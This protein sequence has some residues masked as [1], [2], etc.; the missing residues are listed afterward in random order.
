LDGRLV[1]LA[2]GIGSRMRRSPLAAAQADDALADDALIKDADRKA[3]AMI[4]V[5]PG[6][7]PFLDYLLL[8]AEAVGYR[9]VVIV[10]NDQDQSIRAYYES[11][12]LK[13]PL[14]DLRITFAIQEIPAGRTKPLGTADALLQ[15]L[16]SRPDWD[17]GKFTICN[18]DNL[19][20]QAALR[21]LL[22]TPHDHALVAYDRDALG[23][24]EERVAK[25]AVIKRNVPGYVTGIQEKP[26]VAEL[27]ALQRQQG[28]VEVSMNLFAFTYGRILPVL[29]QVPIHPKRQEKEIPTAVNMLAA[30]RED[31][32]MGYPLAE[33]VPD[34]TSKEDIGPVMK[35]LRA[36][37]GDQFFD[38]R[39]FD[40]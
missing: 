11:G 16:L 18:S 4:G 17:G 33:Q 7:R 40:H 10:V 8:N 19:Y 15:A 27:T 23:F 1:I 9:D 36:L 26:S 25:F 28:R 35:Q 5:G 3:K 13:P 2:G 20:S 21:Q 39:T 30:A 12:G 14:D 34:L 22:T 31:A 24:D 37:Y 32:M 29:R 6:Q 38:N